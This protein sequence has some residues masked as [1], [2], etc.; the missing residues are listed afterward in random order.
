MKWSMRNSSHVACLLIAL[1]LVRT[2]QSTHSPTFGKAMTP[3]FNAWKDFETLFVGTKDLSGR[4][5]KVLGAPPLI[6]QALAQRLSQYLPKSKQYAAGCRTHANQIS[7]GP[8]GERGVYDLLLPPQTQHGQCVAPTEN[9]S[10]IQ[11]Q[12]PHSTLE[13]FEA[14]EELPPAE[15]VWEALFRRRPDKPRYPAPEQPQLN[16][17][18]LSFVN[19]FHD[20]SFRTQPGTSGTHTWT[21]DVG[22]R[23]AHIYGHT[24]ERIQALR[25]FQEG[26]MKV[27]RIG[28]WGYFPPSLETIRRDF[29][30]FEMWT[31]QTSRFNSTAA[32][33]TDQSVS[34]KDYFAI[35]DPRFNMQP[36][37]IFWASVGLYVHNVACDTIIQS[38]SGTTTLSDEDIFQR[39]RVVTFH[40][41]QKIRLHEFVSD[42][43]AHTRE[44]FRLVYDPPTIQRDIAKYLAFQG[45]G[46]PNFL[47]FNHVYQAWHSLIPETISLNGNPQTMREL[48]WKPDL[49]HTNDISDIALGF[50]D[51]PITKYGAHNFPIFLKHVTI[52][53]LENERKQRLQPYNAY[54]QALG[55]APLQSFDEL[56]LESDMR[57]V[58]RNLYSDN[59]DALEF[60]PGILSDSKSK[61]SGNW[62]GDMQV[63]VVAL[64][65]L[66]DVASSDLINNDMMWSE[67]YLTKGG[68][69]MIRS[70][71]FSEVLAKMTSNPVEPPCPFRTSSSVCVAPT[72]WVFFDTVPNTFLSMEGSCS[73]IGIDVTEWF[74]DDG[75]YFRT[76]FAV[77]ILCMAIVLVLFVAVFVLLSY[78]FPFPKTY[79]SEFDSLSRS[80]MLSATFTEESNDVVM[81]QVQD[82]MWSSR[83][84]LCALGVNTL[85]TLG[86]C[87]PGTRLCL[88]VFG[89]P[90]WIGDLGNTDFLPLSIV[91][92]FLLAVFLGESTMRLANWRYLRSGTEW[93]TINVIFH[94]LMGILMCFLAT[95]STDVYSLKLAL[96]A[97]TS[98]M[99]EWS[100]YLPMFLLRYVSARRRAFLPH[101][102]M[103][104]MDRFI[105]RWVF[106]VCLTVYAGTRIVTMIAF[107]EAAVCGLDRLVLSEVV[108]YVGSFYTMS[109]ILAILLVLQCNAGWGFYCMW[110]ASLAKLADK[111]NSEAKTTIT[112]D[113]TTDHAD[114]SSTHYDGDVEEHEGDIPSPDLKRR[115]NRVEDREKVI[116]C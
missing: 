65:A 81:R 115:R 61:L 32:G 116:T 112:R 50:Q 97:N 26:K 86:C 55:L 71:E 70:F 9:M 63:I 94:H 34:E 100:I 49:F 44:H 95:I 58:V 43:V 24:S 113:S 57:E 75:T 102:K 87:L 19:W 66:N 7:V 28:S 37:H 39:A 64:L 36:G 104:P 83:L 35:G 6:L 13:S 68:M 59:I 51:S 114:P 90:N 54:R 41:V 52:D 40:I 31:P 22:L 4:A 2:A 3:Q 92:G 8:Q 82:N 76:L 1:L 77:L 73:F 38:W 56:D 107:V 96:L 80:M 47:E 30:D 45:S 60:L 11:W 89:D 109:L 69:D 21:K 108:E 93:S 88:K 106:P 67:D 20:D 10:E 5:Q 15:L 18:F 17:L 48:M 99:W 42:S 46:Y 29:P 101:S 105:L 27:Q 85:V 16:F 110:K 53:A 78:S 79:S 72:E 14:L 84:R 74:Y 12:A 33:K 91:T 103:G 111:K 23:L 98:F 25:S 62:M